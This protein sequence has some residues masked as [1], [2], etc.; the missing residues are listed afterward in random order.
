MYL[1]SDQFNLYICIYKMHVNGVW[2]D[3]K[4]LIVITNFA[5]RQKNKIKKYGHEIL[6]QISLYHISYLN[7]MENFRTGYQICIVKHPSGFS[8]YTCM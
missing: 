1:I 2:E 3:A 8:K 7:T 5:R 6:L 4:N